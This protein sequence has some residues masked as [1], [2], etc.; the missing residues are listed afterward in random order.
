METNTAAKEKWDFHLEGQVAFQKWQVSP[1]TTKIGSN[2]AP[3]KK[4][5]LLQTWTK[6]ITHTTKGEIV[7]RRTHCQIRPS[8]EITWRAA[9]AAF[10][11][12]VLLSPRQNP[13]L[14]DSTSR[15][16]RQRVL[17]SWA[18]FY[19]C[20]F[21]HL[22]LTESFPLPRREALFCSV[23]Q[24]I[25]LPDADRRLIGNVSVINV[26]P[27]NCSPV[28]STQGSWSKR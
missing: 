4:C 25:F 5:D 27:S 13:S 28:L 19:C 26:P 6:A 3:N 18:L 17:W 16:V 20:T 21:S 24:D 14:S 8:C 11:L 2:S 22:G 23:L 10:C 15:G 12:N 7:F 1:L 9:G